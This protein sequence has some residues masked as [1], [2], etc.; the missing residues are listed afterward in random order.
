ME[1]SITRTSTRDP[2]RDRDDRPRTDATLAEIPPWSSVGRDSDGPSASALRLNGISRVLDRLR[3][4]REG[5]KERIARESRGEKR[6]AGS[7]TGH[8]TVY[9]T[10]KRT[11]CN[12]ACLMPA[13][14]E[15]VLDESRNQGV[16]HR[17]TGRRLGDGGRWKAGNGVAG[18]RW[19]NARCWWD[20]WESRRGR[21]DTKRSARMYIRHV[22][23]RSMHA[24][25]RAYVRAGV[26]AH[27]APAPC[28][29]PSLDLSRI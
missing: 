23:V 9:R 14:A 26:P 4:G 20:W 19:C 27:A 11:C 15:E 6:D 25:L 1:R 7:C 13:R 24:H 22:C 5:E 2:D 17:D 28:E 12:T 21:R 18:R 3:E 10:R 8:H 16:R 29:P